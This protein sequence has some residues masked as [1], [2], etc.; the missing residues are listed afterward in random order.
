[1]LAARDTDDDVLLAADAVG[2]RRSRDR[3]L[4]GRSPASLS[5]G[6]F[7]RDVRHAMEARIEHLVGQGLARRQGQR[8]I[9]ARNLLDTLRQLYHPSTEGA[10][11]EGTYRQRVD[12]ASGR[13]MMID[14]GLGFT[15]VPWSAALEHHLGRQVSGI[16]RNSRMEWRLVGLRGPTIG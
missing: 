2:H 3:Q 7:G 15:L 5:S 8:V 10:P 16:L 6:G 14:D 12:L 9:F 1:M 4:V 11:V 13:F